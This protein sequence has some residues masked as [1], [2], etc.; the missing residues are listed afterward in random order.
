MLPKDSCK[1][2]IITKKCYKV[3]VLT[4]FIYLEINFHSID[5]ENADITH[6]SYLAACE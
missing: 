1:I 5:T 4:W 3:S 2:K 6:L